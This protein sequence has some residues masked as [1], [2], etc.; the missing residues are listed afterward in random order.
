MC[1]QDSNPEIFYPS[2]KR[3]AA[4]VIP[5]IP[6]EKPPDLSFLQPSVL[7]LSRPVIAKTSSYRQAVLNAFVPSPHRALN[8]NLPVQ[9]EAPPPN[10]HTNI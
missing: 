9:E 1:R 5:Q 2:K 3:L 8:C 10:P 6:F 7:G 4:V